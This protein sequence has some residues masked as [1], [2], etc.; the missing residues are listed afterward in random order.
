MPDP[1]VVIFLRKRKEALLASEQ[2]RMRSLAK[3]WLK[4]EQA[5]ESQMLAVASELSKSNMVTEALVQK[6]ERFIKLLYQARAEVAKFNDVAEGSITKTQKEMSKQGIQDAVKALKVTYK[7]AGVVMPSFNVL[8]VRA[9]EIMFGFASDGSP[10]RN[11]F[12]RSYPEAVNGM[13]DA[14]VKGLTL[15]H[16]PTDVGR[17]MA[18][19]FGVGLNKALTIARTETLR[20]YR[21]GSFEQYRESGV[22]SGYKR[23]AAHDSRVCPGC[24]FRDGQ[25]IDSLDGEF[26]EHPNGR[27]TAVPVVIGV[28]EP[29]WINGTKWFLGQSETTQREILGQQRFDAWKKGANLQDMSKFVSSP[30]WGGSY[31]PT[32]VAELSR[33]NANNE[34]WDKLPEFWKRYYKEV[35]ESI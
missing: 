34:E 17:Q 32:P 21:M 13:M 31:V 2:V 22:V 30:N 15:G 8:P 33:I 7:S 19:E 9:L 12:N 11:L 16:H 23:L 10:L 29:K 6:N 25:I 1:D 35:Q 28:P 26:D 18:E 4:V 14:L 24:L 27:C 3:S 20:S 5:L